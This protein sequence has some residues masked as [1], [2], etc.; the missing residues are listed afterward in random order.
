MHSHTTTKVTTIPKCDFCRET[1]YADAKTTIGPWAY[2][3]KRHLRTHGI[4]LGLGKGQQLIKEE[5]QPCHSN[6]TVPQQK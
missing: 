5:E 4:G 6:E 1:A 3:C 2:L